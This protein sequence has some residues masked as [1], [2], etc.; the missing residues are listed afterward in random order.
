MTQIVLGDHQFFF[1]ILVD[2][3]VQL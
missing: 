3:S 1:V 2:V